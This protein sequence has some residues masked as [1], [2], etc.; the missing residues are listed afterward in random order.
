MN[1][2]E[3]VQFDNPYGYDECPKDRYP[4]ADRY[5]DCYYFSSFPLWLEEAINNRRVE[6]IYYN[7]KSPSN[8]VTH[9]IVRTIDWYSES[10]N[11][12]RQGDWIVKGL[13]DQLYACKELLFKT[14]TNIVK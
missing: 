5:S 9:I 6:L 8:S 4:N 14:L 2:T 11:I 1:F 10:E 3:A 12:V 13:D 7:A